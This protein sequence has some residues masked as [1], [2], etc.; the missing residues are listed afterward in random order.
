[1]GYKYFIP[2]F[3]KYFIYVACIIFPVLSFLLQILKTGKKLFV[4][5]IPYRI[6]W[7]IKFPLSNF[8]FNCCIFMQLA[9]GG[10]NPE[11]C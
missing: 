3:S 5:R 8:S 2:L 10:G 11:K 7:Y 4:Y 1:M 9:A 6:L